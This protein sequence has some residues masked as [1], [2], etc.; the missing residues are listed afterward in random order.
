MVLFHHLKFNRSEGLIKLEVP[1]P[2]KLLFWDYIWMTYTSSLFVF[3]HLL[4]LQTQYFVS[5]MPF[6]LVIHLE[7]LFWHLFEISLNLNES[8]LVAEGEDKQSHNWWESLLIVVTFS[9]CIGFLSRCALYMSI[10]PSIIQ[11]TFKT[12]FLIMGLRS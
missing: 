3:A 6:C 5:C 12:H 8:L 9:L 10:Y 7:I 1:L 11:L 2:R 4:W